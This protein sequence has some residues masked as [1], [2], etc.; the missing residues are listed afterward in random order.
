MPPSKNTINTLV[1]I[2]SFQSFCYTYRLC[3]FFY[4][5]LVYIPLCNLFL[6]KNAPQQLS[7]P[8]AFYNL[9]LILFKSYIYV[10]YMYVIYSFQ[11]K[12]YTRHNE[13][14]QQ[15]PFHSPHPQFSSPRV[16]H[17]QLS[18]LFLLEQIYVLLDN[19][20]LGLF[21]S[22]KVQTLKMCPTTEDKDLKL[23]NSL[24]NAHIFPLFW[25]L[26]NNFHF[27]IQCL[28]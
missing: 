17:L 7:F 14:L 25:E 5:I 19:I 11:I 13:K 18:S 26:Y 22:F 24:L 15:P 1:Y 12:Q 23:M 16:R 27:I 10:F 3:T 20:P 21:L 2:L 8:V 4:D 9:I 28:H 6:V